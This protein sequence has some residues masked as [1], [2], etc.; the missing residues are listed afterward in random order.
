MSMDDD[1]PPE[2]LARENTAAAVEAERRRL[3]GLL[4]S[5][6]VEPLNLLLSQANAYEQTIGANPTARMAVSVL[7]SLARQVLQH[8]RDL[9]A[10]LHPTI[11]EALGLE[12]A[13]EA[14]VAQ[15]MR[16]HGLQITFAAARLNQRLPSPLETA[17]F[18]ATQDALDRA[19]RHARASQVAIRLS[20]RDDGLTFTIGDNGFPGGEESL[21]AACRRLEE[22]GCAIRLAADPF[23]LW[24]RVPLSPSIQLTPRELETLQLLAAGLSNKEIA[25]ALSVSPR[26]V[27]FHLDNLYSKLGVNSR[28]EAA[29]Y[30]VRHGL[31]KPPPD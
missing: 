24:V 23:E 12:P 1:A 6:I 28:T 26:T 9:E 5:N 29:M 16:A 19:V 30:A 15:A 13:L 31:V 17:L 11:L 27:N 25:R 10:N 4:Q 2:L 22:L 20:R 14:L 3:A 18:R 8:A 21:R 7:A